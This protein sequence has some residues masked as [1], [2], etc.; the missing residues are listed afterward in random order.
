MKRYEC[1]STHCFNVASYNAVISVIMVECYEKRYNGNHIPDVYY[2]I[3]NDKK[4]MT[5]VREFLDILDKF[6]FFAN[7]TVSLLFPFWN[8]TLKKHCYGTE[9]K[10][11]EYTDHITWS[12]VACGNIE[13]NNDNVIDLL[14]EKSNMCVFPDGAVEKIFFYEKPI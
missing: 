7:R 13:L 9:G 4:E 10:Y 2:I 12:G 5:T 6:G 8:S 14:K 1:I 11:F 3:Y